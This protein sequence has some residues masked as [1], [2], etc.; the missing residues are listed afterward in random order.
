MYLIPSLSGILPDPHNRQQQMLLSILTLTDR[1]TDNNKMTQLQGITSKAAYIPRFLKLNHTTISCRNLR[2]FFTSVQNAMETDPVVT[3]LT[4][5]QLEE[6]APKPQPY[7]TFINSR[8]QLMHPKDNGRASKNGAASDITHLRVITW[9]VDFMAPQAQARMASAMAHLH[10]LVQELPPTTAAVIMLQEMM[11]DDPLDFDDLGR[12]TGPDEANDLGQIASA[13]WVQEGFHVTDLTTDFWRCNYNG[14][15][16]IDRRLSIEKVARLP[17][18]SEY[19]REALLVDVGLATPTDKAQEQDDKPQVLRLCNVHLDSMAG[20]PP[21]RPIQWK[22]CARYLQDRSGGVVAGIL[23]GD[24][25]A[26]QKYDITLPHENGFKDV[27]IELG[28]EEGDPDGNTWGP[29]SRQT[30]FPHR[31]MDKV[32]FCG[33]DGRNTEQGPLRLKNLQKVGVGVK[34]EDEAAAKE[35]EEEGYGGF[36]TDHYGLMVEFEVGE[37][38]SFS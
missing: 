30:R 37:N 28:G 3:R 1:Q 29:Q 11:Q 26:N 38:V 5:K 6:Y 19:N 35:L 7:H 14:V 2:T 34:V 22:A 15:T 20:K 10:T 9:N 16:L 33:Q 36:V 31:R 17:F 13:R 25:N 18:V 21:L 4:R 12:E 8:W 27:Y 23:A 32:C 24:C